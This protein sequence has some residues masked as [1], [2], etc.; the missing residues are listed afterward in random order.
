[1]RLERIIEFARHRREEASWEALGP[2]DDR[3]EP[4]LVFA[5]DGK[6]VATVFMPQ[7]IRDEVL[8]CAMVGV[9]G[10][11]ADE[12]VVVLDG[13]AAYGPEA[14]EL[15]NDFDGGDMQKEC[16]ENA[17]RHRD[18]VTDVLVV[19]HAR[20][21]HDTLTVKSYP[22]VVDYDEGKLTWTDLPMDDIASNEGYIPDTF[23]RIFS[24]R[25]L[26]DWVTN[27]DDPVAVLMMS[28]LRKI[29]EDDPTAR[30]K[31]VMSTI[32]EYFIDNHGATVVGP[33]DERDPMED[34]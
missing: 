16:E 23:R 11:G 6:T 10:Y 26:E 17:G 32:N 25:K 8:H 22:Y 13:H 14:G 24:L 15:A 28:V 7:Q 29:T 19:T 12:V 9:R 34:K 27:P 1:M 21:G 5:R 2:D 20:A 4:M 18:G 31:I 30:T 3:F 33:G